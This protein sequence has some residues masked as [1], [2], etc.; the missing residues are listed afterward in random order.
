[1]RIVLV[2]PLLSLLALPA[3]AADIEPRDLMVRGEERAVPV[4][5]YAAPEAGLRPAVPILH[6]AGGIAGYPEPYVRFATAVA[7][8]GMDA[9]LFSYY[10]AADAAAMG[11]AD[12]ETR[13]ARFAA[14]LDA[15]T[16]LVGDIAGYALGRKD[17]SGRV[18]LAGFSNGGFLAVA[19][20]ARD[21]RIAALAVFYGGIPAALAGK[22][23]RLP[24]LLAI[25]GAA[26]RIV[27]FAYG[28]E[29]VATARA[30][31]G[32]AKLLIYAGAAHAF[33]FDPANPAG[34][35]ARHTAIAFLKRE[36]A[37]P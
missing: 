23:A 33:D 1:M 21:P 37:A 4:Q 8:A 16:R 34:I 14:R 7:E 28:E 25:H 17:S 32:Q 22:I 11:S 12:R 31:G 13:I 3:A 9:Y 30:L 18:G 27:P 20:A 2:L 36:L 26:D 24:P 35:E 29:L 19:S 10:S 5:L 15:W 6:G